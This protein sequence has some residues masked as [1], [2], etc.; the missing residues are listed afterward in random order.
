MWQK[1]LIELA[2]AFLLK[3]GT[4]LYGWYI[5]AKKLKDISKNQNKKT[6]AIEDAKTPE[7]IRTAHRNNKL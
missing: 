2:K 1:L 6:K 3:V 7:E 4:Y 5:Q